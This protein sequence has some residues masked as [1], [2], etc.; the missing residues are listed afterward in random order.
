MSKTFDV[1]LTQTVKAYWRL[2]AESATVLLNK[3]RYDPF[4]RTE[5]NVIGLQVAF[6]LVILGLIGTAYSLLYHDISA[7]IVQGIRDAI[8]TN[9]VQTIAPVI[10][11][12]T[13]A[14]RT[15][16]LMGLIGSIVLVTVLFGYIIAHVTLAPA[17][18]A[19]S[20]QKQ[21]V[22]NIAHEVRTPLS[23]IK[24]NTE[25]ALLGEVPL[26]LKQTLESNI[27]E[28]DRI[29]EIINN[30]LSLS[31]LVRPERMEFSSVDLSAVATDVVQKFSQLAR[32]NELQIMLRKSPDANVWGNATALT[33]IVGNLL[34]NAITYTPHGGHIRVTVEPA[35]NNQVELIVQDSGIGIARKDL[36]RIFEPFYR[37]DPSRTKGAGGS[38]LGLAIVSELIKT[39]QGRITIRSAVGRGTTVSVLFPGAI[40][41]T[42]VGQEADTRD[43]LNE[44]AVDFSGRS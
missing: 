26:D 37:A 11:K 14:I 31:A 16:N 32:R 18:N 44:I 24:T 27:E 39:H 6:G 42:K 9:S 21:F 20:A 7:T 35:P 29:S 2:F 23:V 3:Y 22:G 30:L 13:E 33:Q 1:N 43:S 4:F 40:H 8:S 5:T 12:N 28:L 19:L 10:I 34:K 38:G 36:F 17:R 25:V 15:L 41:H